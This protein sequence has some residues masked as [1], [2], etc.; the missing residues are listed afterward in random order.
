LPK[1][2]WTQVPRLG[3]CIARATCVGIT[4]FAAATAQAAAVAD[5]RE[6]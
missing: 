2:L 5:R 3:Y 4:L 1:W 6:P